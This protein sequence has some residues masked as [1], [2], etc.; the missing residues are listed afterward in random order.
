MSYVYESFEPGLWTVGHYSPDGKFH[1]ESD[2]QDSQ[3][4][5]G[6]VQMTVLAV[7]P[8]AAGPLGGQ[9]AGWRDLCV[10][11]QFTLRVDGG[12]PS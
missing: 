6:R 12:Q 7:R 4:A 11:L 5:A 2:H 10:D 1:P 8:L 9:P 3:E